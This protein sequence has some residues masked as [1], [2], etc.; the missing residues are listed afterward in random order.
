MST[1]AMVGIRNNDD[2]ITYIYNHY[3]GHPSEVGLTLHQHYK[4]EQQVREL[5]AFG[6]TRRVEPVPYDMIGKLADTM[7]T[8]RLSGLMNRIGAP[9]YKRLS[10]T[11]MEPLDGGAETTDAVSFERLLNDGI[12]WL[13]LF[14]PDSTPAS[15]RWW[16]KRAGWAWIALPDAVGMYANS[17]AGKA[18]RSRL[19]ER[20]AECGIEL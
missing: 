17:M 6:N 4:I 5:I 1:R 16:V 14:D 10:D 8:D 20:A 18:N 2:T 12:D 9:A 3:D 19:S 15:R 11:Y 13:Y 7:G